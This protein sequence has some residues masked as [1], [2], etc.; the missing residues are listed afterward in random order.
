MCNERLPQVRRAAAFDDV[1]DERCQVCFGAA[2]TLEHRFEC[3]KVRELVAT[4]DLPDDVRRH[5]AALSAFKRHLLSSHGLIAA[6]DPSRYEWSEEW[7]EWT[8]VPPDRLIPDLSRCLCA[9]KNARWMG[10]SWVRPLCLHRRH[11][12]GCPQGNSPEIENHHTRNGTVA[13][14][15]RDCKAVVDTLR[16]G[17]AVATRRSKRYAK[18]EEDAIRR[19]PPPRER[20]RGS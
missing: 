7:S 12:C 1:A 8:V 3:P 15:P 2:G 5:I 13:T 14:S 11:V 19:T 20:F 16:A 18:L 17:R 6:P 9:R 4:R 10:Y